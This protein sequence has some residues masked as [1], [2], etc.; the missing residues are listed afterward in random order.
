MV[1]KAQS[2]LV[3]TGGASDPETAFSE[4]GEGDE[5]GFQNWLE[6]LEFHCRCAAGG[7]GSMQGRFL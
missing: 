3:F 4:I 7:Q 6:V 1:R 5:S 2:G